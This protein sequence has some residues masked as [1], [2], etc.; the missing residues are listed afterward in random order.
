[1]E[2]KGLSHFPS[3]ENKELKL[4][5]EICC[6]VIKSLITDSMAWSHNVEVVFAH[7]PRMFV[8]LLDFMEEVLAH[9]FR[10]L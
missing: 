7:A 5:A 6:S 3:D 10:S 2:N 1:M 9:I 4:I 8:W